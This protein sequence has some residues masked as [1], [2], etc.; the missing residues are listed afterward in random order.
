M[1]GETST[2]SFALDREV[3]KIQ[4]RIQQEISLTDDEIQ[5]MSEQLT[6]YKSEIVR[7]EKTLD[8]L[9]RDIN[10]KMAAKD[11]RTKR[12]TVNQKMQFAQIQSDYH[13]YLQNLKKQQEE[14]ISKLQDD[15][16]EKLI[17]F[18]NST[19]DSIERKYQQVDKEMEELRSQI[20]I[21]STIVSK[22]TRV[23]DPIQAETRAHCETLNNNLILELRQIIQNKNQERA[24]NLRQ[25]KEKLMQCVETIEDIDKEHDREV[26]DRRKALEH[27]DRMYDKE[28]RKLAQAQEHKLLML[29]GH[30]LEAEKRTQILRRA[31][32]KLEQSNEQ[33]LHETMKEIDMM[34][35]QDTSKSDYQQM[36]KE[37]EK[38]NM[39]NQKKAELAQ[40]LRE[41][42][43]VLEKTRAE[44]SQV[45]KD[46]AQVRHI[47]KFTTHR[48]ERESK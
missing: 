1:S 41:R 22:R 14:E 42:E 17:L 9:Q 16:E 2:V 39:L 18:Q 48:A 47:I 24:E 32:H 13:L 19:N 38:G 46:I 4:F 26:Q 6:E 20:S 43:Q 34:H 21:H 15:F 40:K 5:R 27:L 25:S 8:K 11:G 7:K 45:K 28:L 31:A 30:L 35:I 12:N 23:K 29:K 10:E 36:L 3:K 37:Q 33:Q 44:N